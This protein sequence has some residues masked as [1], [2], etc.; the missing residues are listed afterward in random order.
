MANALLIGMLA[1]PIILMTL[2]RINAALVFLSV[3]LGSVLLR[4]VGPDATSLMDLFSAHSSSVSRSTVQLALLLIPVV[5]T[6]VFMIRSVKGKKT[7]V[8]L[9]LA[10]G[11]SFL[12]LLLVKPLLSPGVIGTINTSPLWGQL[13]RSQD[14][15]VG[16]SAL[17]CLLFLWLQ[18]PKLAND[19]K[20]HH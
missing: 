7:L 5:L 4:F 3:C 9:L 14:L 6:M 12:L 20:K 16:S 2:L 19:H 15:I 18:R 13:T 8:N 10:A 11:T 17:I 1:V